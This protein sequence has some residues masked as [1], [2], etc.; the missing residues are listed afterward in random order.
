MVDEEACRAVVVDV[1][2]SHGLIDCGCETKQLQ[3]E[4][5]DVEGL[6]E[7]A[8]DEATNAN[9]MASDV[10]AVLAAGYPISCRGLLTLCP[11]LLL[12]CNFAMLSV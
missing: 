1:R 4:E 3:Y 8:D 2:S 7:S 12:Y 6:Y 9:N 10:V 5:E 11:I